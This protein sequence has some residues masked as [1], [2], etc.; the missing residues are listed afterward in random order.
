ML[1]LRCL[2]LAGCALV[3]A[4]LPGCGGSRQWEITAENKSDVPCSVA[5]VMGP[6]SNRTAKVS[7]LTK[8][9]AYV[10]IAGSSTMIVRSVK[11]VR[12][13]EEQI[14]KPDVELS[15]GKRYVIVVGEDGKV[16][17]SIKDR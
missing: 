17:A 11:V 9:R 12:G 5:V 15:P 6:D 13:K 16:E 4:A 1:Q 2:F 3:A 14:L 10:L 7:D 8:E